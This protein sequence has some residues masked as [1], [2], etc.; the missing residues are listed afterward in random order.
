MPYPSQSRFLPPLN[1]TWPRFAT[2]MASLVAALGLSSCAIV[3]V[4]NSYGFEAIFLENGLPKDEVQVLIETNGDNYCCITD[5]DG[6]IFLPKKSS[7]EVSWLGGPILMNQLEQK[8]LLLV[9]GYEPVSI[10]Y[11]SILPER[12]TR[13]N[14]MTIQ[15]E[16][17]ILI[18]GKIG[19]ERKEGLDGKSK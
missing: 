3:E 2:C 7:Y 14:E 1:L 6:K 17:G 15:E 10:Y 19:L 9:D 4:V 11:S 12:S 8:Y 5:E 13:L 16:G 18:I